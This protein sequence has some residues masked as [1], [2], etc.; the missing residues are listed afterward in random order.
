MRSFLLLSLTTLLLFSFSCAEEAEDP[1]CALDCNTCAD[2]C[3]KTHCG[4]QVVFSPSCEGLAGEAE[5]AVDQCLQPETLSPGQ[6]A[7]LCQALPIHGH[8]YVTIRSEER[9]WGAEVTCED[10]D[11]GGIIVVT[12]A[13]DE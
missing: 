3:P 5:I 1:S 10:S 2:S 6:G 13:C 12:A 4:L 8:K 9:L 11:G 7:Y